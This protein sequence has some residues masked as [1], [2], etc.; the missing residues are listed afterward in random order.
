[1]RESQI[2]P[3]L[4]EHGFLIPNYKILTEFETL[5]FH[6][7]PSVLKI[8]SPHITHK[9]DVGGVVY[10]LSTHEQVQEAQQQ[11]IKNLSLNG[12]TFDSETDQF[13]LIQMLFGVE[14]FTGIVNDP[15]FGKVIAF[16]RGGTTIELDQ[17]VCFF[18]IDASRE[19]IKRAL[20]TTKISKLFLGFRN[21][22]LTM[23]HLLDW[24]EKF[25]KFIIKHPNIEQL[26]FNPV[27]ANESGFTIVDSR[28]LMNNNPAEFNANTTHSRPEVFQN[29][30]IAI[31][32]ASTDKNKVGYALAK[33]TIGYPGKLFFV[34][35]KGGELNGKII[36][37]SLEDIQDDIDMA[38][39]TIPAEAIIRTLQQLIDKKIKNVVII[40]AGFKECGAIGMEQVLQKIA[41]EHSINIIGPNCL[42]YYHGESALNATFATSDISP[43]TLALISQS[44]AVL[45]S[46]MDIA[47]E[48]QIGFS[49]LLSLGNMANTDF[50]IIL[51]MLDRDPACETISLYI[52]GIENGEAFLKALRDTS[53]PVCVYKSGQTSQAQK[54][55]FSHTGNLCG[56]HR[57]FQSLMH[58]VGVNV[59][60]TF[61]GLL[62]HRHHPFES[63]LILTNGGGPGTILTD[64]VIS[65]GK[66]LYTMSEKQINLLNSVLPY[67]WSKNNPVDIIGD[68]DH[69]RFEKTLKIIENFT[70][71]DLIFMLVTPQQMTDPLAI[72]KII[73]KYV[74][75]P[76][77]PILLG[78]KL[79]HPAEKFLQEKKIMYFKS[80]D[81]AATVLV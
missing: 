61:Q 12:L 22:H 70:G 14:L 52:E 29:Q 15:S 27:I 50:S 11:I 64:I 2:Y 1:M 60:D 42:G 75:I 51:P 35:P 9:S 73:S 24:L 69:E 78:G 81:Q 45:S 40:S 31:I 23:D 25:Q 21:F 44:G 37:K 32:G 68:A 53:K 65:K 10:P 58:S 6:S 74:K 47:S 41:E 17:D 7:Y 26:D 79:M 5:D 80:L 46:L 33:N 56:N 36:H 19:E 38:I 55:A 43:G 72:V 13:L 34:N 3:W 62:Y 63:V 4:Q 67:N 16:G 77:I 28:I 76:V 54:A 48:Q 66:N 30:S 59:L 49:H 57:L 71:L 39:L 8:D 20:L 18:S